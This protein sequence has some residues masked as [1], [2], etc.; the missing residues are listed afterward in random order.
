[1]RTEPVSEPVSQ[2]RTE[3]VSEPVSQPR[4]EPVSE[5]VSQPRTEPV[6]QPVSQPRTEPV[7]GHL[8]DAQQY[9]PV[10]YFPKANPQPEIPFKAG[11]PKQSPPPP[12]EPKVKVR[13]PSF[14]TINPKLGHASTP[15]GTYTPNHHRT[16][17]HH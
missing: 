15:K 6:S 2:L 12:A 7:S 13:P 3:P 5:P 10:S 17:D 14:R 1:V 9:E 4:T 8:A 16:Q 11:A